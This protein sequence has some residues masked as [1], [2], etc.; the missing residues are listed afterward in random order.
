ML[1]VCFDFSRGK[2]YRVYLDLE[3]QNSP[4]HVAKKQKDCKQHNQH[5]SSVQTTTRWNVACLPLPFQSQS[6][7]AAQFSAHS[8]FTY[9]KHNQS[10]MKT[11]KCT[12]SKMKNRIAWKVQGRYLKYHTVSD[13]FLFFFFNF[14]KKLRTVICHLGPLSFPKFICLLLS[15]FSSVLSFDLLHPS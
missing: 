8:S 7:P 5:V 10:Y 3:C 4:F 11:G 12:K 13:N 14:R 15:S 1:M 6:L 9:R 2:F